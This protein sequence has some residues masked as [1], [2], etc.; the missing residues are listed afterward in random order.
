MPVILL[1]RS[2]QSVRLIPVKYEF[3]GPKSDGP[4]EDWIVVEGE[5]VSE[6][7]AWTFQGAALDAAEC[8]MLGKWL[9]EAAHSKVLPTEPD[10]DPTLTFIEPALAFSVASYG[11]QVVRLR[12][13]LGYEAA[14]PWQDIDERMSRWTFFVQLTVGIGDLEVA[15]AD[16]NREAG[17]FPPRRRKR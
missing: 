7:G 6:E 16:W 17:V 14:P 4:T 13:H 1:D 10:D 2:H 3:G 5:V 8:P 11:N 15:A 9:M 12:V